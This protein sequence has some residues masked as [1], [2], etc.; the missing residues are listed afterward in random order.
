MIVKRSQQTTGLLMTKMLVRVLAMSLVVITLSSCDRGEWET[1]EEEGGFKGAAKWDH[2]LAARRFLEGMGVWAEKRNDITVLPEPWEDVAL[3][4]PTETIDSEARVEAFSSW[5]GNGGHLIFINDGNRPGLQSKITFTDE[6]GDEQEIEFDDASND[7]EID[8]ASE[9]M[10]RVGLEFGEISSED[11]VSGVVRVSFSGELFEV[12]L[13]RG[14]HG[15]RDAGTEDSYAAVATMIYGAGRLTYMAHATPFTNEEISEH[16]HAA[17]LWQLVSLDPDSVEVNW[18]RGGRVSLWGLLKAHAWHL[19]I[20]LAVL[21]FFWLWRNLRR[22][23]PPAPDP[24]GSN[25]E[26]LGHLEATGD[27]LWRV[28]RPTLMVDSLR[29]RVISE[30][31]GSLPPGMSVERGLAELSGRTE[32]E[33]RETLTSEP[34]TDGPGFVRMIRELQNL[35][36][37]IKDR[38]GGGD[39]SDTTQTTFKTS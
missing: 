33:I 30:C 2:F 14:C 3:I 5:M 32:D 11:R 12:G 37:S 36:L 1:V 26:Y 31:R 38:Q 21:I 9:L 7:V 22:F 25:R 19:L 29:R 4:V 24:E 13:P 16:D 17:L 34:D 39:L 28:K 8:H 23:G 35:I 10:S 27:Y 20:C 18:L 6:D 15:V